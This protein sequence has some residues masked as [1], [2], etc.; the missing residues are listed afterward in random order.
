[1][2]G[3]GKRSAT[4]IHVSG[5]MV[6]VAALQ[7]SR[8]GVWPLALVESEL[9]RPF[10]AAALADDEQRQGLVSTLAEIADEC[11]F[12]YDN[13]CI[14]LDRRLALVKRRPLVADADK[15]NHEQLLWESEQLLAAEAGEYSLDFVLTQDWGFI[16]AAR[17]S[18]LDYYLD[19]GDEAGVGRLDVDLAP[20]ALYNAGECADLLPGEESELLLYTDLAEAWL[21]LMEAGEPLA[22]ANCSWEEEDVVVDVLEGTARKLLQEAGDDIQRIWGAGAGDMAWSEELA[23]R[24]GAPRSILDPLAAV[25]PEM[26]GDDATPEQRSVYAIAVGLAQ[27]GLAG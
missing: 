3:F 15:D 10:D 25:D 6:R 11:G 22:V 19:L 21:L 27:R 20:F 24:L 23:A 13:A 12:D 16:V 2:F 1:M 17:Y 18:A 4:G 7:A 9:E 8:A 26:L 14:A 5:R